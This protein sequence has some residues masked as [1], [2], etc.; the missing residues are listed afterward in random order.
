MSGLDQIKEEQLN[1][2]CA[3]CRRATGAVVKCAFGHC[4]TLLHPLCARRHGCYLAARQ[5][6]YGRLHYRMYCGA[7]SEQMRIKDQELAE[8]K[9]IGVRPW[10]VYLHWLSN[11]SSL[12]ASCRRLYEWQPAP[13]A[14]CDLEAAAALAGTCVLMHR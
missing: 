6:Q 7:H 8:A 4:T 14:A 3:H 10:S 12:L 2:Q 9:A 1:L 11:V 5:G 13:A